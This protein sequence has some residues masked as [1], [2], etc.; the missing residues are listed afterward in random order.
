[1]RDP[2]PDPDQ[3]PGY[4]PDRSFGFNLYDAARLLGNDFERRARPHGVTR[5]QW[6]VLVW[7]TAQ[8]ELRQSQLA[9]LA[10]VS[11]IAIARLVDRMEAEGLLTRHPDPN[12]RR[13]WRLALTARARARMET[14]RSIAIDVRATAL[15]GFT[16]Q[17]QEFLLDALRRI[18]GNLAAGD[19]G[20]PSPP[21]ENP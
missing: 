15:A 1:M 5:A 17:E 4:D 14:M 16:E 2:A 11:P 10:D 20:H 13:A 19:G 9:E 21:A 12:D 7:L 8:P 18:R 3:D 6:R